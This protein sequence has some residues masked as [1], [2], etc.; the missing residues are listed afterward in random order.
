VVF[1]DDAWNT[2]HRA[3]LLMKRR[4]QLAEWQKMKPTDDKDDT[5][6]RKIL[7]SV[8]EDLLLIKK[9]KIMITPNILNKMMRDR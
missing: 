3:D 8:K 9:G 7:Y 2:V 1:I 6:L 4:A 5:H